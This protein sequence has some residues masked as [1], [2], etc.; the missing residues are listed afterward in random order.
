MIFQ[1]IFSLL[2]PIKMERMEHLHFRKLDIKMMCDDQAALA[3][4]KCL[5][6]THMRQKRLD[7]SEG[8][9]LLEQMVLIAKK[10]NNVFGY[11]YVIHEIHDDISCELFP[12]YNDVRIFDDPKEFLISAQGEIL[13]DPITM[14]DVQIHRVGNHTFTTTTQRR[15]SFNFEQLI[16]HTR[17][18]N[19]YGADDGG[20]EWD[21]TIENFGTN[22]ASD[23]D[24]SLDIKFVQQHGRYR[25]MLLED[26]RNLRTLRQFTQKELEYL[27]R[28]LERDLTTLASIRP[29]KMRGA[30]LVLLFY[31]V[32]KRTKQYALNAFAN[33][34]VRNAIPFDRQVIV[35]S[36]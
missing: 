7:P 20:D 17:Y 6:E 30:S 4:A 19:S 2:F 32:S 21:S 34:F 3:E 9:S 25:E 16:S 13:P 28:T 11:G 27:D 33:T 18:Y 12:K 10:L 26:D 14:T 15:L 5:L 22:D 35:G 23:D 24:T 36:Y 1:S 31:P 29:R 8:G